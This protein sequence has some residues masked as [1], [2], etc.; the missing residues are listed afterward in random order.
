LLELPEGVR[1]HLEQHGTLIVPTRQRAAAVRLAYGA[2]MVARGRRTWASPDV[3]PFRAWLEREL[4]R[5][6]VLGAVLPRRLSGLS[7]WLLWREAVLN[8]A[9]PRAVLAPLQLI[10][11]LRTTVALLEDY[12]ITPSASDSPEAALLLAA[13]SH[14]RR[15]CEALGAL[16]SG[17]WVACARFV[18][19]SARVM[20]TGFT[21]IG[22]ALRAWLEQHDARVLAPTGGEAHSPCVAHAQTPASEAESAA[23]WCA[24]RLTADPTARLL[25][26]VPRLA[27][28]RPLWQRALAQRLDY[29]RIL[30]PVAA[31]ARPSAYAIEGGQPL[32]SFPLVRAALAVIRL[33][34]DQLD[35]E[36]LSALLRSP[37]L[38]AWDLAQ[39]CRLDVWLRQQNIDVAARAPLE[40]LRGRISR[41]L[42]SAA[43]ELLRSLLSGTAAAGSID[44]SSWAR[45]FAAWLS[46]PQWP[47][48]AL[49]S[50]EL[51]VRVRFDELLGELATVEA[52]RA[53]LTLGDAASLLCE[54][55]SRTS[56]EPASDDVAVTLTSSLADPIVRYDGIWVAGLTAEAW[57]APVQPDPFLPLALQYAA[58]LPQ[59]SAETQLQRARQMQQ[60][61]AQRGVQCVLSWPASEEERPSDPSPL[62]QGLPT[63]ASGADRFSLAHWLAGLAAP[64]RALRDVRGPR[65]PVGQPL[66]GGVRL[67]ELQALCPFRGFTQLR[68]HAL[69][70]PRPRPGVD[71]R[72]RGQILHRSLELLWQEIR[73]W[74]ALVAFEP[75]DAR[76][77][78]RRCATRATREVMQTHGAGLY[79]ELLQRERE[80]TQALLLQALEWERAREPFSAQALETK[81]PLALGEGALRLRLDRVDRL[82][83][84]RL[85]IIDYKSGQDR[86]FDPLA[87]RLTQ[88]QLPAYA[89]ALGEAVAAVLTLHVRPRS[90][91]AR[92][93]ADRPDRI[94]KLPG[95]P[96]GTAWPSLL[97]RW[98]GQLQDLAREFLGG[99]AAVDPQP[100]ACKHCHLH[101]LCRIDASAWAA[102]DEPGN[103]AAGEH[104]VAIEEAP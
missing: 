10:D 32:D 76:D 24:Q 60:L 62:L 77:L 7:A 44:T 69:E 28:Q 50:D 9:E 36:S 18:R 12:G 72:W 6:R 40:A 53:P 1:A 45:L 42:G 11:P 2:A 43:V 66:P 56:F 51:Q 8:A 75:E 89:V 79:T 14:F 88:P 74:D 30:R 70:L 81:Q 57:P 95:P 16:D 52:G 25:I 20:L 49:G 83:D 35:F 5:A 82:A 73:N 37:Y 17:S 13:R 39:R 104:A 92:G 65:W 46:A 47:G 3:L 99:H 67:L 87:E 33:G 26:V 100:D 102:G 15:S 55:A 63:Y 90:V 78:V 4:D 41:E 84:G 64:L 48:S 86:G 93:I 58:G 85:A 31:A 22:P 34:A 27:E 19:P 54:L 103:A 101:T 68:L 61:W 80:R 21:A 94:R 91:R 23:E 71:G 59:S 38:P 97:A 98:H 29:E 96:P